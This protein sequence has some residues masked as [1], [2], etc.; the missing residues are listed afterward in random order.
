MKW[1]DGN[2]WTL[3]VDLPEGSDVEFKVQQNIHSKIRS[4]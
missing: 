3:D 2:V 1:N 4:C